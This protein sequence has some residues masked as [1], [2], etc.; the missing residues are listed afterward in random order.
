M[1]VS[2]RQSVE[3]CKFPK[4]RYQGSKRK[5]ANWI[6]ESIQFLEFEKVADLFGGT[7]AVSYMFKQNDKA[8]VFNDILTSNYYCGLALIENTSEV[9]TSEDIEKILSMNPNIEDKVQRLFSNIYYTDEENRFIDNYMTNL[10]EYYD[11]L[12]YKKALLLWCLFQS[13]IIKRPFNL[14]HRKNLYMRLN[15]VNRTF[16]NKITWDRPF[17]LY[18]K[19]FAEEINRAVFDEKKY[20]QAYNLDVFDLNVDFDL[21]Y[22]DT[23]YIAKNGTN[24]DYYQFY[25]F[26]EGLCKYN[27]WENLIDYKKKHLPLRAHHNVWN[28]KDSIGKAFI[29]L[30]EKYRNSHLVVSYRSDGIPS[31]SELE[32]NMKMF[33]KH[34]II[35][36]YGEYKYVLS[37]NHH[38]QEVLIIGYD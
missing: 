18:I 38:S 37:Q 10:Q 34:A 30:F 23:P 3:L 8:V 15:N 5:I 11:D 33:K 22:I 7:A 28:S 31:I 4:T 17:N 13:C 6:W 14:F 16:G 24:I 19:K 32:K 1:N 21:V 36:S 12:K 35:T 2:E 9:I 26:I 25:H 29:R 20:Y 27:E